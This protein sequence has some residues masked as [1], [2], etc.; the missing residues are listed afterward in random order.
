MLTHFVRSAWIK[1][2]TLLF[3]IFNFSD[4]KKNIENYCSDLLIFV[5]LES[6]QHSIALVNTFRN[7]TTQCR[8]FINRW[9]LT[10]IQ[11]K[12]GFEWIISRKILVGFTQFLFCWN[13]H[14]IIFRKRTG[15][16]ALRRNAA[17]LFH[18]IGGFWLSPNQNWAF[19]G[20][21]LEKY[22]SDLHNFCF[23]GIYTKLSFVN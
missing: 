20:P 22:W 12:L 5:L 9:V 16:R 6:T 11:S 3:P 1:S 8:W 17:E 21:Y 15:F 13:L 19:N 7:T 4:L 18:K 23:V 14:E 2:K 10:F